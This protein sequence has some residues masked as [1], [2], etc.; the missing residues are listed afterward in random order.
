LS[1]FVKVQGPQY[2]CGLRNAS[3]KESINAAHFALSVDTSL[4][5]PR[6]LFEVLL[7]MMLL[8]L[9][10]RGAFISAKMGPR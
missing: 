2:V 6:D 1:S 9:S 8:S 4:A 10:I 7:M 5:I 3:I